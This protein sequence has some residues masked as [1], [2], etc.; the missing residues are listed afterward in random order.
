M[1][2]PT[3]T[4]PAREPGQPTAAVPAAPNRPLLGVALS[5][6]AVL[7]FAG[8]DTITKLLTATHHYP[9][10]LVAWARYTAQLILMTALL[11][12]RHGRTLVTPTRPVPVILRSLSL[13]GAT[14]FM[15]LALRRLPL[16]EAEA[17][18][19]T[20]PMLVVLLAA[21][22]LG[23]RLSA[24]R[25]A[26]ALL[27]FTGVLLIARPTGHLDTLGVLFA[28]ACA[29]VTT[30]YNL[31]S[32]TLRAERPLTLLFNSALVGA[33]AFGL[34]APFSWTGDPL[35]PALTGMFL[36][37]GVL[38]GVG[39]FLLTLS[40]RLAPAASIAPVSYLQLFWAGVLGILVFGHTPDPPAL[41]GMGIIAA[42]GVATVMSGT[43]TPAT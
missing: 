1:A 6:V 41:L 8:M 19:F 24:G 2:D 5:V 27:G 32:R 23:E 12:P 11:A 17:I 28:L 26:L 39:H 14:L 30:A 37:L 9:V 3:L 25:A 35:T 36:A 4:A 38:A 20:S 16:A 34:L 13:V 18:V 40:Y 43:R 33:V 22:V 29:A 7:L 42:S 31:M 21:P 15:G 10:P